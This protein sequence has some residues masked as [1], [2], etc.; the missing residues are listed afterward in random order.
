[1]ADWRDWLSIMRPGDYALLLVLLAA[2]LVITPLCWSQQAATRV[3]VFQNGKLFAE[4]D[5][6]SE[7]TIQLA[8]PLGE[9]VVE[10]AAGRARIAS[11]PS[12]R[13]YCVQAGWLS[14]VGQSAI[15]LPNRSSIELVGQ[16]APVYDSL[17][18]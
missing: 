15:C 17:S 3:K 9:T 13:Q 4:F 10:L 8:G 18:Y 7:R 11:D 16:Q 6:N 1:M 5:L 12:P 2:L 14:Q